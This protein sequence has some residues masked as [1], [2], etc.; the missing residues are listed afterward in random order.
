MAWLRIQRPHTLQATP[1]SHRGTEQ[2]NLTCLSGPIWC[3]LVQAYV[4]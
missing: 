1:H 4:T 2:H 3:P